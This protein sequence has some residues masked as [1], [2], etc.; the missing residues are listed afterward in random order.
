MM[1]LFEKKDCPIRVGY[2]GEYRIAIE[3]HWCISVDAVSGSIKMSG[4]A[5]TER[6]VAVVTR[7]PVVLLLDHGD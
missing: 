1:I 4:M 5:G 2:D 6:T 3:G 7:E